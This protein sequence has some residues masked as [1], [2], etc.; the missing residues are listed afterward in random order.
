MYLRDMAIRGNRARRGSDLKGAR[1][2][3]KKM[4]RVWRGSAVQTPR[5]YSC[6]CYTA[7]RRIHPLLKYILHNYMYN[8]PRPAAPR[9]FTDSLDLLAGCISSEC[10]YSC[11]VVC[12]PP[13]ASARFVIVTSA[14][15]ETLQTTEKRQR[16]KD[17]VLWSRP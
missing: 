11:L 5:R 14:C 10:M 15:S 16:P 7:T 4:L 17:A 3:T 2:R 12:T 8:Y 6:G 13:K 9:S 1:F